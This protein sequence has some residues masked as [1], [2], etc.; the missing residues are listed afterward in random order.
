MITQ[1][2]ELRRQRAAE[3]F[4]RAADTARLLEQ[5]ARARREP[6]WRWL[7]N[8]DT[9]AVKDAAVE[10]DRLGIASSGLPRSGVRR[11]TPWH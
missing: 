4:I 7:R 9:Q 3:A 2:Q 10:L 5:V 1:T 6:T 8:A 11:A